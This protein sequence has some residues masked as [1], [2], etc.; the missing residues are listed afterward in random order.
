LDRAGRAE[1]SKLLGRLAEGDRT[2]FR[3]AFDRLWP[4]LR[5][6]ASRMT[7]DDSED[8]AQLA[9]V[10]VFARAADYDPERDA[11]V[12]ALG[13]AAW[14]CRTLRKKR[15]R[16]REEAPAEL[17]SHESPES[18]LIDEQLKQLALE[19]LGT[20][21]PIDSETL[22]AMANDERDSTAA[23]RKRLSRALARFRTAWRTRHGND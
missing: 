19:L 22:L 8:A 18:L 3:P 10:K 23:F 16:R 5:A 14:E 4:L 1:L 20:L 12:W 2:A 6:L 9:M 11:A 13:I 15:S 7:P 21:R 17:E